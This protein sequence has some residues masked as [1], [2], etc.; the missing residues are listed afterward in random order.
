MNR[1]VLL[2]DLA[3]G[4]VRLRWTNSRSISRW[5]DMLWTKVKLRKERKCAVTGAMI[6]K[7]SVAW[8]PVTN[9]NNRMDRISQE[10][11][12]LL[13]ERTIV[14]ASVRSAD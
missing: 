1:Y 4:I 10:G 12:D 8:S 6:Q 14:L 2:N 9:G 13:R 3:D 5:D 7:G 11:I